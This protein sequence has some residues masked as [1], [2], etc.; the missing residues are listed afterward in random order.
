M[1]IDGG[2][3]LENDGYWGM[4]IIAG[5]GYAFKVAARATDGFTG[6]LTVKLISSTGQELSS[7]QIPSLTGEWKYYR[8]DLAAT[9][10]DPKGKLQISAAGRGAL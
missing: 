4:N 6:P 8:L 3:S 7:G 5:E 9:G 2:F 1:K 10:T